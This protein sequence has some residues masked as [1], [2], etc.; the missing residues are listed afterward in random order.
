M[1]N[2][3][4]IPLFKWVF[5]LMAVLLVAVVFACINTAAG[6]GVI[7]MSPF[8]LAGFTD[9][10]SKSF[11]EWM[12]K[13]SDAIQLKVKSLIEAAKDGELLTELKTMIQGDGKESKGL[14]ALIP[15]MQKQLDDQNIEIQKSRMQ[16]ND[17][18][19]VSLEKSIRQ[20]FDSKEF[21][22]AKATGFKTKSMFQVKA[23][24]SDITGT[25]NMTQQRLQVKFNPE[26]ALAFMPYLNVGVIGND[27]NRVLWVEGAYTS[28]VGYVGEGTGQANADTGTA[29]E[30]TR[31]MCKISAKLPLTAELLED[32]EYVASAFRMKMQEKAMLFTDLEC[33]A[34]D[35]SDGVNPNHIYGI[36]GHATAYSA[37]TTGTTGANGVVDANIGDLI[38]DM[39]L[40]GE[41]SEQRGMNVLW[42]NPKDFGKFK[43]AKDLNGQYLFVKDVNGQYSI[44][45]LNVVKSTAV[46]VNT[47]TIADSAKIQL[48]WKRNLEVKFSQMNGTDFV[49]DT[50]TAV[51]FLRNQ[52]VVEGPDKT[53]LIHV[54][55]INAAIAAITFV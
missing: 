10:Q 12:E 21:K 22:D 45:G 44:S 18:E 15:I 4:R 38:D 29:T 52:V 2:L 28:N 3:F 25:I 8:I 36:K 43:R 17:E 46:T 6:S 7:M 37:A 50:Y 42:M 49:D 14:A 9:E 26:R 53:A 35:G 33:Y 30:K 5:G 32:A 13:Q 40:Q 41:L 1:K 55:D 51:L 31:A 27:K 48:W 11:G 47:M 39:I 16:K 54:A 24:T 20:L 34:G 23:A 19:A